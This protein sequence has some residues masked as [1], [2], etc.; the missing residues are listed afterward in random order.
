[1]ISPFPTNKSDAVIWS[2]IVRSMI[3]AE[4]RLVNERIG[5][6]T[7]VQG[8]L[9]ASLGI[10]WDKPNAIEFIRVLCGLGISV[11]LI[12]FMALVGATRA[13]V[14][15]IGWWDATRPSHFSGPDVVGLRPPR[16]PLF[17]KYL[18]PW[19][20]L[21]FVFIL[22]WIII[23]LVTEKMAATQAFHVPPI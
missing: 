3:D 11:A 16:T 21:A 20:W 4:N 23:W 12:V 10:V 18:A 6:L 1:M 13:Q 19:N 8:L 9:F 5:W 17:L 22:A 15:L 14:E 2:G 7:T